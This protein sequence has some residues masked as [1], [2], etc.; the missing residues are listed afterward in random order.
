MCACE[1]YLV[2]LSV[3]IFKL[4]LKDGFLILFCA[5]ILSACDGPVKVSDENLKD[6]ITGNYVGSS[7]CFECHQEQFNKWDESHHAKAMQHATDSTILGNFESVTLKSSG[8]TAKFY[9]DDG[10]YFINSESGDGSYV[11]FEVKY[12]FGL[13][14]LQQYLVEL[15]KGKLQAFRFAW[16]IDNEKWYDLYPDQ[17][18]IPQDWLHWTR[19]GLNWNT[20]CAE[21]HSTDVKKNYSPEDFSYQTTFNQINVSCE[22]CHDSG[23][24]HVQWA[25]KELTEE[26]Y[27]VDKFIRVSSEQ[28]DQIRSCAPCHA[29]KGNIDS[30]FT[31]T[32]DILD[33]FIPEILI[34]GLYHADGQIEDEVYVYGSFLQSKMHENGVKCNDCHDT[35][36]LKLKFEGNA[37]CLQCHEPKYDSPS[38]TFHSKSEEAQLCISCHMTGKNYMGID[39]RRDHSFRVP[40]PDQSVAF[41]TPNA[42][43]G[44]HSNE[45]NEWASLNVKNWY[46]KSRKFH[47]SDALTIGRLRVFESIEPLSKLLADYNQP[48]IARA[49]AAYYLADIP[50]QES[51]YALQNQLKDSSSL[52]RYY[53]LSAIVN[54]PVEQRV[55]IASPMLQDSI[56][57]VRIEA[58]EVLADVDINQIPKEYQ[59]SFTV[60][61]I[62]YEK[63]LENRLDFPMGRFMA[64]QYQYRKGNIEGALKRFEEALVMDTLL[65]IARENMARIYNQQGKNDLAIKTLKTTISLDSENGQAYYSLGL[66]EAENSNL[67]EAEKNLEKAVSINPQNERAVYNLGLALQ[68]QEKVK[69]AQDVYIAGLENLPNST[70]IMNALAILYIQNGEKAKAKPLVDQLARLFPQDQGIQQLVEAVRAQ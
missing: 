8:I 2:V 21:C 67:V 39:F 1:N 52:V 15:N 16:D 6:K 49:T 4:N 48:D 29:R 35:H 59:N 17:E 27:D 18:I 22:S 58:A 43:V 26:E 28:K 5:I 57:G 50:T 60:A 47:F 10:K 9:K 64:G 32:G 61:V 25:K 31:F 11:D 37:L 42:C 65:H 33:S 70:T 44:C 12:T 41:G 20:M 40:R 69:K 63:M 19:G 68:H 53:A 54:L 13:Y 66:I 14:P 30:K 56:R 23:E 3:N 51:Y 7:A 55:Q 45:T 62:E 46:G 38:H 36:S 34:D 24:K